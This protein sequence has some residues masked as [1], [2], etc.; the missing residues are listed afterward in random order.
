MARP[1]RI[2]FTCLPRFIWQADI[3]GFAW[4]GRELPSSHARRFEQ[5][6]NATIRHGSIATLDDMMYLLVFAR[7]SSAED[8]CIHGQFSLKS[9]APKGMIGLAYVAS[10]LISILGQMRCLPSWLS[11]AAHW[12]PIGGIFA[13]RSSPTYVWRIC[14]GGH[15]NTVPML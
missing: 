12:S 4:T 8:A 9:S 7:D 15:T 11:M 6:L 14:C 13:P 10:A 2:S 3:Q 1:S 5:A